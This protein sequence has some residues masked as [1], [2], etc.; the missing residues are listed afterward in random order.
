MHTEL[1]MYTEFHRLGAPTDWELVSSLVDR[2]RYAVGFRQA[3][4]RNIA[5]GAHRERIKL[6]TGTGS[7]LRVCVSP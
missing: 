4:C 5:R 3:N 6:D 7:V 1:K 2:S